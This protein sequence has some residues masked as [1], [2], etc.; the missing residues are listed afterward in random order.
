[1]A[2]VLL[3]VYVGLGG[4]VDEVY[5]QWDHCSSPSTTCDMCH[6]MCHDRHAVITLMIDMKQTTPN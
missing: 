6:D 4:D 5:G 2:R 3:C 1:M